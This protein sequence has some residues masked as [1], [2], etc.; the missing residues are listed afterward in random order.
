MMIQLNP[1]I[2][3]QTSRGPALAHILI[4]YGAEFD[5]IWV[6]F[7]ADGQIWAWRNNDVRSQTNLTFGRENNVR[8]T[9]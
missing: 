2:P 9:S 3:L 1:P 8:S 5:L 6:C 7:D 4:D